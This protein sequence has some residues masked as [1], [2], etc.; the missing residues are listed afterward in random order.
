MSEIKLSSGRRLGY[1]EY[2]SP[3]G[4]AI[5]FFHGFP[6][7]SIQGKMF[8]QSRFVNKYRLIALDR[9]G[10]G[11]S[12]HCND[13]Q[14]I[15]FVKDVREF[16]KEFKLGQ[17]H[18]IGVSGGGPYAMATAA[19]YPESVRSLNLFCP[20]GPIYQIP[21]LMKL[22][23][24]AQ[25]LLM[26]AKCLPKITQKV[27][28]KTLADMGS[29]K[30]SSDKSSIM[31]K[32]AAQLPQSDITI[33]SDPGVQEILTISLQEAFAQGA[34]GPLHELKLFTTPWNF[35]LEHI[36]APT[37]ILH[38]ADDSIVPCSIGKVIS[39][40]IKGS[41]IEIVPNEGH[42]SLPIKH[43]DMVLSRITNP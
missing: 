16:T 27:F 8:E 9:P 42:Y 17:F 39:E 22:P 2:G 12:D 31:E 11:K 1:R 26:A 38:G 21:V 10:F 5:L 15:D 3:T 43:I 35:K 19:L 41:Q 6:G 23:R 18:V 30:A 36:K 29:G 28:E 20:L 34:Q 25:M 37:F 4:E 24:K 32:F 7:S 14:L 13:R 40:R 33:M